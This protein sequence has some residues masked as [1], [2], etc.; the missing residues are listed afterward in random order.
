MGRGF[1]RRRAAGLSVA[2]AAALAGVLPAAAGTGGGGSFVGGPH[3]VATVA[4]TIPAN[5]TAVTTTSLSS[6]RE[7][8][9]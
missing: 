5:K 7:A 6:L 1:V 3:T 9:S 2:A 8:R 4:S